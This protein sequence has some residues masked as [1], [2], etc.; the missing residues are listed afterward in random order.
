M[1]NSLSS[2]SMAMRSIHPALTP[3]SAAIIALICVSPLGLMVAALLFETGGSFSYSRDDAYVDLAF[4]QQLAHGHFGLTSGA[5][6]SPTSSILWPFLLVP[7]SVI[8]GIGAA[9]PFL[10]NVIFLVASIAVMLRTFRD[11]RLEYA[12][13]IV[14]AL[15]YTFN[16][17][18]L[19]LM[20]LEHSLQ[21]LLT[22]V[23]VSWMIRPSDWRTPPL[24]WVF[25][26]ALFALPLVRYEGLALTVPITAYLMWKPETRVMGG[27]V[28]G[29]CAV[30][31]ALFSGAL[32]WLGLGAL[33]TPALAAKPHGFDVG[34]AIFDAQKLA[35][36]HYAFITVIAFMLMY[37]FVMARRLSVLLLPFFLISWVGMGFGDD[38]LDVAVLLVAAVVGVRL[39]LINPHAWMVVYVLWLF[40]PEMTGASLREVKRAVV[41]QEQQST[42]NA[43]AEVTDGP[44]V[45][46]MPG[47]GMQ[48]F[49]SGVVDVSGRTN[50]T[51]HRKRAQEFFVGS[52][53]LQEQALQTGA[54][55]AVVDFR[56]LHA[57]PP[58]WI[59]VAV[60]SSPHFTPRDELFFFATDDGQSHQLRQ[61]LEQKGIAGMTILGAKP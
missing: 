50:Y 42:L 18:G 37:S 47:I 25:Y 41:L 29:A 4:A 11:V 46:T 22:L 32:L 24:Q 20:G 51:S 5:F 38:R 56:S 7:W 23:I 58:T 45:T 8:P 19:V 15:F 6:E 14:V 39:A 48:S 3:A 35:S 40:A 34:F 61:G 52:R 31:V 44:L 1:S 26:G 60:Q 16:V 12:A 13:V 17:Y 49:E 27:V 30:S 10:F 21:V 55:V 33:P 36:F 57:I 59:N 9:I 2:L 53:W 54:G 43:L 28:L